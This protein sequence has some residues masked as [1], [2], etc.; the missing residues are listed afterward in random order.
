[1]FKTQ[2]KK[3]EKVLEHC[4]VGVLETLNVAWEPKNHADIERII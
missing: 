1:M 3:Q 2:T 4:L